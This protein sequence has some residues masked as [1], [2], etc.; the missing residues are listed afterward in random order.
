MLILKIAKDVH[1]RGIVLL[2]AFDDDNV[3]IRVGVPQSSV[4]R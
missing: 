1:K 2:K 4:V 3:K